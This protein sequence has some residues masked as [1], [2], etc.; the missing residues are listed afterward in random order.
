[1]FGLRQGSHSEDVHE[2]VTSRP[3]IT[4]SPSSHPAS[5]HGDEVDDASPQHLGD[6]LIPHIRING[7]NGSRPAFCFP[8]HLLSACS[9]SSRNMCPFSNSITSRE[10]LS[11]IVGGAPA[12]GTLAMYGIRSCWTK[13]WRHRILAPAGW[14]PT[15]RQAARCRHCRG[16]GSRAGWLL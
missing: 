8:I 7:V 6:A 10:I 11:G 12:Q 5:D 13:V 16:E 14:M 4:F 15:A 1:M 3:Q 9:G 2:T